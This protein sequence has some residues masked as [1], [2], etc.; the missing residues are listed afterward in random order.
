MRNPLIHSRF[1]RASTALIAA[2]IAAA[3]LGVLAAPAGA[4]VSAK[5]TKFC[6][7]LSSDQGAGIDFEGLSAA[8]GEYAA[9]L[10]R[11]LA[12]TGVPAKLKK[13]LKKLAK[14]YDRIADGEPA[15]TVVAEE[16]TA[17]SKG[18]IRFSKYTAKNCSPVVP[19]T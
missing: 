1:G 2:G 12:K 5:N 4:A 16:E 17:I 10:V 7:T 13:D 15:A 9:K 19:A 6:E 18:L 11:K 3:S 14:I 8:E